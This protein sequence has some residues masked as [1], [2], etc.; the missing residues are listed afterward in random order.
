MVGKA[1]GASFWDVVTAPR[2]IAALELSV[3]LSLATAAI[4][5]VTGTLVAW[6]LV[7]DRFPGK[8]VVNS[9]VD[10]PF[11]LPTIVAGLT[12][13]ALYGP[14]GGLG[15]NVAF[16]R[17]GVALA[18]LGPGTP[19]LLGLHKATFAVWLASMTVHVLA[20]ALRIPALASPDLRGDPRVGGSRLRLALVAGAV[21][22]GAVLA[23]ATIPLAAPWVDWLHSYSWQ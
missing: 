16:T 1:T 9:L 3:G 15:V 2:A 6:V 5:A 10:L 17:A 19:H 20:H 8:S 13:L 14:R 4:N 23:V 18:L 7:R 22:A 12:L 21:V 11:A